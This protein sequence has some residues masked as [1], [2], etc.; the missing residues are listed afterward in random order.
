M[1]SYDIRD[2]GEVLGDECCIEDQVDQR[3]LNRQQELRYL[4][5]SQNDSYLLIFLDLIRENCF[6]SNHEA[7][8]RKIR[9]DLTR[10][11]GSMSIELRLEDFDDI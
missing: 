5:I 1:G 6:H 7:L 9:L 2:F 11:P 8:I 4:K 3:G 10:F